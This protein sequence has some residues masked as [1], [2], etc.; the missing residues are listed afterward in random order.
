MPAAIVKVAA[1]TRVNRSGLVTAM[2]IALRGSAGCAMPARI[3]T[4]TPASAPVASPTAS[5]RPKYSASSPSASPTPGAR[6][7]V[8]GGSGGGGADIMSVAAFTG[9]SFP[10]AWGRR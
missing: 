3:P 9:A 10:A 2:R 7:G 1:V 5:C 8:G 4:T 6:T